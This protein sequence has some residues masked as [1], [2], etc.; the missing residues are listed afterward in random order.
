LRLPEK[1]KSQLNT[2]KGKLILIS[3]FLYFDMLPNGQTFLVLYFQGGF[4]HILKP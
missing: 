2:C 4:N 1:A 3:V